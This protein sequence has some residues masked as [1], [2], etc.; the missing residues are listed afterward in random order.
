MLQGMH[1]FLAVA[2][3]ATLQSGHVWAAEHVVI[4][5]RNHP[6]PPNMHDVLTG[7]DLDVDHQNVS[8]V[9]NNSAFSGFAATIKSQHLDC[10]S[11]MDGVF[12]EESIRVAHTGVIPRDTTYQDRLNATWGLERVSNVFF[13][14]RDPQNMDYSYT[15]AGDNPGEGA[16]IY[17]VD[18]GI[19]VDHAGFDG[20]ASMIWTFDGNWTDTDGHGTHVAGTAGAYDFG[21]ASAANIFGVR[22]L[23]DKG[24]GSTATVISGIDYIIQQHEQRKVN[25]TGFRGSV[26]SVSLAASGTVS[27]L[28]QAIAAAVSAGVHTCVAAGNAG[29]DACTGS[30]AA[31]GG[32]NG[33]AITVG[34]IGINGQH[35]TFSN[36][37]HCVDIYAPGEQVLSAGLKNPALLVFMSGTSQATPHIT[38]IV[39]YAMSNDTLANSPALMKQWVQDTAI[40]IGDGTSIANNGADLKIEQGMLG[41]KKIATPVHNS[42]FISSQAGLRGASPEKRTVLRRRSRWTVAVPS[43]ET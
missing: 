16:D 43:A 21:V 32:T 41:F 3:A 27:A 10:L 6:A 42:N 18:S 13:Q 37:G 24:L 39:A 7:I 29:I 34:S 1:T 11:N 20:R 9:W 17:I 19:W 25:T 2:L 14:P 4:I 5:D 23:D 15:F 28:D 8:Y 30:P 40:P 31:S 26:M 36:Y 38:G 35:S 33:P 12:L 22:V